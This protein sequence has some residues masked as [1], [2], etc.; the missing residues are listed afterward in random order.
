MVPRVADVFAAVPA[1]LRTVSDIF[2]A[3]GDLLAAIE[4]DGTSDGAAGALRAGGRGEENRQRGEGQKTKHGTRGLVRSP[5][6]RRQ[7]REDVADPWRTGHHLAGSLWLPFAQ[8]ADAPAGASASAA[9]VS[10]ARGRCPGA[11]CRS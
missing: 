8:G 10:S 6:Y 9:W 4:N 5:K 3:V 1:I 11:R 2:A 7:R